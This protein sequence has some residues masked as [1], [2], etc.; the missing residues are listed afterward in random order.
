MKKKAIV[1]V[2]NDLVTDQ[3]VNRT[4]LTLTENGYDVLLIGRVKKNSLPLPQRPYSTKRMKLVFEKGVPFYIEY[5]LRLFIEL[6]YHK[7]DLLFANDLDTL[8]PNYLVSITKL[9]PLVYD[10]HEYF[11]G[12]PELQNSKLKRGIWKM[13]EKL[14]IPKLGFMITVNNS[15]AKLYNDEFGVD[16]KIM[17][18][19]PI[20]R[21]I[22]STKTKK[23]LGLPEDKNIVLLQGAGI[24]VNRGVEEAVQ[25]MQYV[26]NSILLIIGDG[27][28]IEQLKALSQKLNLE[29][30]VEFIPKQPFEELMNYTTLADL[31]LTL[32]KDTNINY[33]YSLPNKLFDYI[34]AGVPVLAS[35]LVEVKNIIDS[36]GIGECI[37][38]HDP[39]HLAKKINL[40]LANKE[41]L[42]TY[43]ANTIKAKEDLC[44]E[45]EKTVLADILHRY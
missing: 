11:T 41:Q 43:K 4:C 30:K 25:A 39:Q 5:Q 29:S 6:L 42:K 9:K 44:W 37:E 1:S 19:L 32:D 10:S 33:R 20:Q 34:Q 3:R 16:V 14:V 31:G 17:R 38:S 13:V 26:E 7:A 24:N 8:L 36:Y 2:I 23:D 21:A 18:N 22:A 45:K 35:P 12:V 15:I 27:D 28:V 40:L